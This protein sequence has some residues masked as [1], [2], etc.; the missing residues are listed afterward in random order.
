MKAG[1]ALEH[2]ASDGHSR[3]PRSDDDEFVAAE[4]GHGVDEPDSPGDD[5]GHGSQDVVAC[6]VTGGV[7]RG[8]EVANVEDRNRNL[9]SLPSRAGELELE[10]PR[11]RPHVGEARQR[12]GVG[13]PL[14]PLGSFR[15][16]RGE[17]RAV[18][19]H[20]HEIGDRPEEVDLRPQRGTRCPT[21]RMR[22]R[23]APA[24]CHRG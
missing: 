11:E 12:I 2:A 21:R 16:R 20:G 10:D 17:T 23:P 4:P 13:E 19:G 6:L 7:V 9:C 5:G 8:R 15:D 24:R 18:H 3:R 22:P 14:E 1:D